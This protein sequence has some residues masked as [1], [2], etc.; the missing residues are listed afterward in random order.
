MRYNA[1]T[2][3]GIDPA[4]YFQIT[5][6]LERHRRSWLGQEKSRS[7]YNYATIHHIELQHVH[8]HKTAVSTFGAIVIVQIA[9]RAQKAS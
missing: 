5:A 9:G 3:R 8:N 1:D 6:I 7:L 4:A 2:I